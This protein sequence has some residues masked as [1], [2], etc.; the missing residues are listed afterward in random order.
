MQ[1]VDQVVVV[2]GV[3]GRRKG[4]I[5]GD[6]RQIFVALGHLHGRV[7]LA[8]VVDLAAVAQVGT[9]LLAELGY[10]RGEP[11]TGC[12]TAGPVGAGTSVRDNRQRAETGRESANPWREDVGEGRR[13]GFTVRGSRL[14]QT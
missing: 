11:G 10:P 8:L 3:G 7:D 9:F 6:Q 4:P 5:L 12:A 1:R 2:L 14:G 13:R